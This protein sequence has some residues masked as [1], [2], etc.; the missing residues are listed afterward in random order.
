MS[1]QQDPELDAFVEALEVTSRAS[2]IAIA[3][4]RS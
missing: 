2:A 3:C 4:A 1:A